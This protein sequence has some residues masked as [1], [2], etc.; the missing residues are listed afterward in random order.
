MSHKERFRYINLFVISANMKPSP[1][2][3]RTQCHSSDKLAVSS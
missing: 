3:Q 2:G 1:I